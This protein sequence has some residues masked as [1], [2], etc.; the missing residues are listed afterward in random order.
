MDQNQIWFHRHLFF[1]QPSTPK[2][3]KQIQETILTIITVEGIGVTLSMIL[4][5]TDVL[6]A[7]S[8]LIMGACTCVENSVRKHRPKKGRSGVELPNK[9]IKGTKIILP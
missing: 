1:H 4:G 9:D 3:V 2:K 5:P 6:A 8:M 7:P